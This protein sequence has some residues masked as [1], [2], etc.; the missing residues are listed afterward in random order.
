M[1]LNEQIIQ[2]APGGEIPVM[3]KQ[4]EMSFDDET[5]EKI[6]YLTKVKKEG[7]INDICNKAIKEFLEVKFKEMK[8]EHYIDPSYEAG[9]VLL[10]E[11]LERE[12]KERD[13]SRLLEIAKAR[14]LQKEIEKIK[15]EEARIREEEKRTGIKATKEKMVKVEMLRDTNYSN[16]LLKEGDQIE[17][18]TDTGLRW[19]KFKIARIVTE[20]G[21]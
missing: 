18:T 4:R 15:E 13:D 9:K 14:I 19:E 10:K 21:K 7:N 8:L 6:T 5:L 11:R 1:N 2:T 3:Q 20:G 17:V 16:M 12:A